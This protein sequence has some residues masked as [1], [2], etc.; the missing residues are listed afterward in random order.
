M[1]IIKEDGQLL[2]LEFNVCGID[3]PQ[4][5]FKRITYSAEDFK[6]LLSFL[7]KQKEYDKNL[8]D[9]IKDIIYYYSENYSRIE[10]IFVGAVY[11]T[12]IF[13]FVFRIPYEL[14]PLFINSTEEDVTKIYAPWRLKIGK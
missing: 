3:I 13:K 7:K 11:R 6:V 4:I 12:D 2:N 9:N 14:V 8:C 10:T 1:H 5:D